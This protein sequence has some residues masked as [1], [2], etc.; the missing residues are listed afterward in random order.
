MIS[1][2]LTQADANWQENIR[3]LEEILA[4]LRPELVEAEAALAEQISALNAFDFQV[5][6]RLGQLTARLNSLTAEIT[7]L[8]QQLRR[9]AYDWDSG[10]S[11]SMAWTT[12]D[13][14][15]AE[16]GDYRYMGS[17]QSPPT[18]PLAPE[19]T[20]DLKKLYRQL[21]FR[22]HPD[23]ADSEE[24]RAYR[25][26]I[27]M[28]INAAYAAGDLVALEQLAQEPDLAPLTP[29]ATPQQIAESLYREVGRVRH[30]LAE[31]K[32]ELAKL[33][34][35]ERTK[36]MRRAER[37][38]AAGRN[39][40]TELAAELKEAIER[41]LVERDILKLELEEQES[42]ES[43]ASEDF[44]DAVWDMV[45]DDGFDQDLSPEYERYTARRRDRFVSEDDILD[46]T[47]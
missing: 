43:F 15:A 42:D 35:H 47:V 38:A 41:K 1:R 22:F 25:T 11:P 28:K 39:L 17:S 45:L 2:E 16:S 13:F 29:D 44:A 30:R 18:Q 21:A 46:D 33:E 9:R 19:A 27:M 24:D 31:I 4:E 23:M 5:R 32:E 26:Q 3:D 40:L 34:R 37:A 20:A 7:H 36:L 12:A 8:R 6:S 14:D 10:D